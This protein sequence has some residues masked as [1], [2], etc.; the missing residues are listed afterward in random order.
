LRLYNGVHIVGGG[1]WGVQLSNTFDCNVYLIESEGHAALLDAGIGMDVEQI[2]SAISAI[3]ISPKQVERIFVTHCHVDHSGG[4]AELKRITGAQAVSSAPC[5]R[6]IEQRAQDVLLESVMREQYSGLRGWAFEPT[7]I[8]LVIEDGADVRIGAG[9]VTAIAAPGHSEGHVVYLWN[10]AAGAPALFSGD[11]V[12]FG[13]TILLQSVPG[14]DIEAY[15]QTLRRLALRTEI[16]LLL[17]G[18]MLFALRHGASHIR[19]AADAFADYRVPPNVDIPHAAL[20]LSG[21]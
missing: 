15:A 10:P 6:A 17:P 19:I 5:A 11:C 1:A 12:F 13:G 3:G 18:H 9:T 14:C 16:E 7:P 21:G 4:L 2:L 8:D 20:G